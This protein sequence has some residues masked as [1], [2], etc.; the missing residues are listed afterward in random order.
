[1][2]GNPACAS[3][4]S[5]ERGA[6]ANSE[7]ESSSRMVRRTGQKAWLDLLQLLCLE[8]PNPTDLRLAKDNR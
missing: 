3:P 2:S 8:R 6:A 5:G 4:G 1:M 7:Y